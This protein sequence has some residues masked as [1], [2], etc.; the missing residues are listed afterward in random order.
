MAQGRLPFQYEME[1]QSSGMTA[2]GGLPAY[3]E[4]FHATGLG[5]LIERH[6]RVHGPTQGWTDE[7]LISALLWLNITGGEC[8]DDIQ[9]LEA[10][11]GLC[12]FIREIEDYGRTSSQ[13][14]ALKRRWR[15]KRERTLPCQSAVL[16]YLE[17]F[18]DEAQEKLREPHTAFI[19]V[20]TEPLKALVQVVGDFIAVVQRWAP[21]ST[22]TL[23]MDATLSQTWKRESFHCY[24]KYKAYQPLNIYWHEHGLVLYSEFRDGNVPANYDLLRVFQEALRQL[25]HGVKKVFL[26]TDSAG[27]V[28][29]L[30]VY[31]AEGKNSR[32]GVIEFAVGADMT[33]EFKKA[34]AE[35]ET[36]WQPLSR[37]VNGKPV[38]TGQE[39]AEV[40]FVPS[41]VGAKKHGP[42]YRFLAIRE[43]LQP[44]KGARKTKEAD[45]PFPTMDFGTVR[46]KVTGLVTNRTIPGDEVIWW[47]RERCG[48][49]E[50]AHSVM[51]ADLAGG[52]FPSK[53]FGANAAWWQIMILALNVNE[54]M[55]RLVFG[56]EWV[57]KRLKAIRFRLI[58][59]PGKVYH[60]ARGLVIRLAGGHRSYDL[61]LAARRRMWSLGGSP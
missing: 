36:V 59:V 27:Y 34:I 1:D 57:T 11:D 5:R 16:Q 7:Q 44:N 17:L 53:H 55:K 40:C 50:E 48:K 30:L 49:S 13:R 61:L 14:R 51:K 18:H 2:L 4:F 3:V 32:F 28:E 23:D 8:V 22:A 29:A 42:E 58:N 12:R 47:Y 15:K 52:K 54:A 35:P 31:C 19:P 37:K 38:A 39:Y 9:V 26:R 25:P 33:Q 41:W 43:P 45:L 21:K 56:K 24:K 60:H 46:Y 20:L 10:D 6:V